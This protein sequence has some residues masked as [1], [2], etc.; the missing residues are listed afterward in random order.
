MCVCVCQR[1][2]LADVDGFKGIIAKKKE[3][4]KSVMITY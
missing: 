3:K 2:G 1:N 4:K